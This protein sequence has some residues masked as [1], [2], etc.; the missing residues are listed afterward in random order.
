MRK[1]IM[2]TEESHEKGLQAGLQ[3]IRQHFDPEKQLVLIDLM[4]KKPKKGLFFGLFQRK[5]VA[6][7]AAITFL[8]AISLPFI[9]LRS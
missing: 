2:A 4:S 5:L 3:A 1:L 8:A 9:I 7:G 6:A